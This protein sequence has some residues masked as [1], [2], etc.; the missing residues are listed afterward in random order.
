[1]PSRYLSL[2][3]RHLKTDYTLIRRPALLNK[4]F[5]LASPDH[6]RMVITAVNPFA[7]KE[8]VSTGMAVADARVL[9]PGLEVLDDS[10]GLTGKLLRMLALWC[11]RYTPTVGVDQPDGLIMDI[12]GCAHLWGGERAYLTQI[13]NT[14]RGKGYDVRAAV[15]DTI[16]AA[17]AVAR[18]GNTTPLVEPGEHAKTLLHLPTAALK[19]DPAIESRLRRL[20]LD[21]IHRIAG[22]PRQ[23]LLTRFGNQLLLRLDQAFGRADELIE[24]VVPV[25][26][27]SERLPCLEPIRTA[28]GIGIALTRLLETL[29]QRLRQDGKGLRSAVFKGYRLD[30]RIVETSIGTHRATHHIA[31][32]LR[33]FEENIATLEPDLGIEVFTLEALVVED[34]APLQPAM[35]SGTTGLQDNGLSELV[36]RITNKTGPRTIHRYLPAQHYWPE[37]AMTATTSLDE[38]AADAWS[39]ARPRPIHILSRPEPIIVTAP[40]PDYPPMLFIH[41]GQRHPITRAEGPERIEQE[42]WLS[43]GEHRDYYFVEDEQGVRFWIFRSG[44]YAGLNSYQWFLHG[45]FA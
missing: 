18:Y 2:W 43:G 29:C 16:A 36:D 40:I 38:I 34:V 3:F 25:E 37:R 17:W 8:G 45:Y 42:W 15:A 28:T 30:G 22:M 5:V 10:P 31:H 32:L 19:I 7:A 20:G 6:G 1:M 33:L 41:K 24:P 26:V 12:S 21:K 11:I 27:Y 44:H 9:I 4:P 35:W 13:L 23:S 14:L 39:V